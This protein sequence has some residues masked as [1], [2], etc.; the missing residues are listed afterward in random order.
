M[1][2]LAKL[3]EHELQDDLAAAKMNLMTMKKLRAGGTTVVWNMPITSIISTEENTI[4]VIEQEL[5][6][7]AARES[8]A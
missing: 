3:P 6:R 4:S 1:T 8:A 7:R 2:D 5:E